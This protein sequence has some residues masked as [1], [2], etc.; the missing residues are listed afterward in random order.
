MDKL[1]NL[2]DLLGLHIGNPLG[3]SPL[4]MLI[5]ILV[6]V[7]TMTLFNHQIRYRGGDRFYPVLYTLFGISLLAVFYYVFQS[8]LPSKAHPASAGTATPRW[9]AT[10][11]SWPSSASP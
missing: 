1:T 8:C 2:P 5:I 11:C 6:L 3:L 10:A 9:W 4:A 7:C